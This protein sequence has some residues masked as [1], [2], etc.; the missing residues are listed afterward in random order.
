[1]EKFF[2]HNFMIVD[3]TAINIVWDG[4]LLFK[5]APKG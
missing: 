3:Q 5:S 2:V 4:V 1:M